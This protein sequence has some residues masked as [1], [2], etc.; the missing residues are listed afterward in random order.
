M[1]KLAGVAGTALGVAILAA[2][3]LAAP[4]QTWP[5]RHGDGPG[6]SSPATL[7]LSQSSTSP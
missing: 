3:V 4:A 5:G 2:G 6:H 7:S 1:N